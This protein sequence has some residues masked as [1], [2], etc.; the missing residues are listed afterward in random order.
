M[1]APTH[2][3]G[4]TLRLWLRLL[5]WQVTTDREGNVAFGIATHLQ[6]DGST[7]RVGGCARTDGELSLQLFEQAMR[8]LAHNHD[9]N[10]PQLAAA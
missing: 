9:Q 10:Q 3:D 6:A 4:A 2:T 8:T 5:G 1:A 7:L